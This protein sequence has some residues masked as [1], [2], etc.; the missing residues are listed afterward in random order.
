MNPVCMQCVFEINGENK[1]DGFI[2]FR[3]AEGV[4]LTFQTSTGLPLGPVTV[5]ID[6]SD[7]SDIA[8]FFTLADVYFWKVVILEPGPPYRDVMCVLSFS[9]DDKGIA[10]HLSLDFETEKMHIETPVDEDTL[11]KMPSVWLIDSE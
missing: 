3:P 11:E 1:V 8:N 6:P 7:C 2:W 4:E 10:I 5:K 9:K